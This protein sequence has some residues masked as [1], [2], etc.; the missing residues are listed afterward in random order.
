MLCA[1]LAVLSPLVFAKGAAMPHGGGGYPHANFQRQGNDNARA[2]GSRAF[3]SYGYRNDHA[4]SYDRSIHVARGGNSAMGAGR[5]NFNSASR[6]GGPNEAFRN[7]PRGYGHGDAGGFQYAGAIT[8]VSAETHSVP[9]PPE[10][11]SLVRAG[12]IRADVARYNEERGANRPA[13]R[14]PEYISRPP[15]PSPYRN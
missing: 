7:D 12:S 15:G 5:G 3:S 1:V 10:D 6:M 2:F 8:T 4:A 9:R 13:P 11:E 14:P